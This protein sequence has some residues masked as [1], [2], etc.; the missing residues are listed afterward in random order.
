MKLS[1]VFGV[2][3]GP[4]GAGKGYPWPGALG[5]PELPCASVDGSRTFIRN[6]VMVESL[7]L[8]FRGSP[9]EAS[10]DRNQAVRG[11]VVVNSAPG[12]S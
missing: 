11:P 5:F 2:A 10:R 9:L 1:L 6:V 8:P 12:A 7:P 4:P 3:V